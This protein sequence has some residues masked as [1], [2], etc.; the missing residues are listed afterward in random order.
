ML[1]RCAGE[2][3]TV[4]SLTASENSGWLHGWQGDGASCIDHQDWTSW[5]TVVLALAIS[6][7][8]VRVLVQVTFRAQ[9]RAQEAA[10]ILRQHLFGVACRELGRSEG[11]E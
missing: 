9:G 5:D 6:R 10:G 11:E 8:R 3:G 1:Y 7:G 2:A 4:M